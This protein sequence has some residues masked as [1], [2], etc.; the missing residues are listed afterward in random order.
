MKLL[1]R[2]SLVLLPCVFASPAAVGQT[3]QDWVKENSQTPSTP[4]QQTVDANTAWSTQSQYF[5]S[6]FLQSCNSHPVA[7]SLPEA[8]VAN[9]C[10]CALEKIQNSYTFEEF[11][12][13]VDYVVQNQQYP[14]EIYDVAKSCI[15]NL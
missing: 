6:G 10:Q 3:W 8:S 2:L 11:S 13:I 9:Y 12:I 4:A 1:A 14:S 15:H 7:A 5:V